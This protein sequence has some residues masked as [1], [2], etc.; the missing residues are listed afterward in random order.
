MSNMS[1]CRFENTDRDLGDCADALERLVHM[2][3]D[4]DSDEGLAEALSVRELAAAKSLIKRC[5]DVVTLIAEDAG[6][7]V[8][9]DEFEG[10]IDATLD[11]INDN[12]QEE[13][14]RELARRNAVEGG[15]S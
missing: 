1:Y 3:G 14:D 10:A 9:S 2:T 8:D 6:I 15:R 4:E 13:R 5:I 7:D 12:A 11:E